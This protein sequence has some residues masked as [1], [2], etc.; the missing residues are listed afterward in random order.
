MHA[1]GLPFEDGIYIQSTV[2]LGVVKGEVFMRFD[3][4][5]NS[6][7]IARDDTVTGPTPTFY[8]DQNGFTVEKRTKISKI[9]LEGNYYPVNTM[10]YIQDEDRGLRLSI[11]V[12][13]AHGFSSFEKGRLET[14]IERRTI[15]DDARGMG[16]GVTDNRETLSNYVILL[17]KIQRSPEP[18]HYES[19]V[20]TMAAHHASQSLSYP[21]S[22]FVLDYQNF[23]ERFQSSTSFSLFSHEFPCDTHLINLRTM[24]EDKL[25]DIE[26][27]LPSNQALMIIQKLGYYCMS[28][29]NGTESCGNGNAKGRSLFYAKTTLNQVSVKKITQ[30]TLTG[31]DNSTFQR[32]PSL[33]TA[34]G[35]PYEIKSLILSF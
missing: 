2:N 26:Q 4:D 10:S 17:E 5:M 33:D 32:I 29:G 28:A 27:N 9:K 24:G 30:T 3:T 35:N 22:Q 12:D 16:E 21:P 6:T 19:S 11:L 31:I 14:L 18:D 23:P 1:G 13:R 8:T 15:Y 25:F 34:L 20:P 7:T